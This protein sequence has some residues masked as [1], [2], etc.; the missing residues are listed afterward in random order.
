MSQVKKI[1]VAAVYG[2]IDIKAVVNSDVPIPVMKIGGQVIGSKLVQSPYGAATALQGQF[3][4]Y[5][6]ETGEEFL[7]STLFLPDVAMVPIMVALSREGVRGVD[8][9]I[10]LQ[11]QPSQSKKAGGVPYEYTFIDLKPASE[12]DPL[13]AVRG[14]LQTTQTPKLAAP[15][16]DAAAVAAPATPAKKRA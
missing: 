7:S 5:H 16:N 1:T 12:S 13:N 15:A 4:A 6:P 14:L 10:E 9:A 11:V 2:R 3:V 8:F